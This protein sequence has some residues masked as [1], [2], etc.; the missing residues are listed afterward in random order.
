M[1]RFLVIAVLVIWALVDAVLTAKSMPT[2]LLKLWGFS[3][4]LVA[5]LVFIAAIA[6]VWDWIESR[7][8]RAKQTKMN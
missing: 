2:I 8:G 6:F 1:I 7:L 5:S 3:Y 4:S